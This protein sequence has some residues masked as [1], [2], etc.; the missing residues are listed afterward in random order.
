VK[1][2]EQAETVVVSSRARAALERVIAQRPGV[3]SL[4]LFPSFRDH[5]KPVPA[6]SADEWLLEAEE[7]AKLD[8]Q[9]GGLWH[10]Y[11]RA[12]ATKRKHNPDVDVAHA[13]GWKDLATLKKSYQQPDDFTI[14][15]VVENPMRLEEKKTHNA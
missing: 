13:G 7:L 11:R 10:P 9:D 5:T 15:N 2:D 6:K 1:H 3:G 8:P 14:Q 12:W 4:P